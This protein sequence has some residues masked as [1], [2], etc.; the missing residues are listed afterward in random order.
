MTMLRSLLMMGVAAS[1]LGSAA[2]AQEPGQDAGAEARDVI[3]VT[4]QRRAESL[5]DVPIAVSAFPESR[6][7][8]LQI[9]EP[10]DLIE[11][12]PNTIGS[13]NT[14]IGQANAYYIRGLGNTETIAT[15]D[16]PVGTYVDEIYVTRQNGNNVA[17]FDV[18]RVEVLRG[19]QGTLFGR[20]TTGGAVAVYMARPEEEFGYF[21][22][23]GVGSYDRY[24]ARGSV[25][26][27]V[28][29]R[30]LTKV[31]GYWIDEE[32]FVDNLTTG[33]TLNGQE[34]HGLRFDLTW[35]AS[36]A[37]RWDLGIERSTDDGMNLLNYVEGGSP[38]AESGDGG[39]RVSRTGLSTRD[40]AG[41][42]LTRILDGCG[43]GVENDT[44]AITSN[45]EVD[46][47][48]GT[49]NF[50]TGYRD[51]DQEFILDF[52]DGG[53]GGQGFATGGFVIGNDGEHE[54]LSQ[55]I[56]YAGSFWNDRV[57]VVAGAFYLTEDNTTEFVDVFT[58]PFGPNGFPFVLANRRLENTLDTAALYSQFDVHV[59]ERL[60]LTAG[61]RWTEERKEIDFFDL[62]SGVP[63][64]QRLDTINL[65][66]NGI[67]TEQTTALITP[68]VAAEY[69]V[70]DDVMVFASYTEGFKSGGWNARGT[71]PALLQPFFRE[72]AKNWEAGIRSQWL[73]DSLLVNATVFHIQVEDLQAP[74][75]FVGPTGAITFITLNEAGLENTGFELE[76]TASPA[77]GLDLYA[78][79]GLQDAE[80]TDL[81]LI[82]I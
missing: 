46:A 6:L 3:T 14:G 35:L 32:G 60:T 73:N 78:I 43:L 38:L 25:D 72:L 33:E 15:F 62:R 66:A 21:V 70:N 69:D 44:L 55:E 1:A 26:L 68:R 31:S 36:D 80:Y 42:L 16:P 56:K 51:L 41:D 13:N 24:L 67:P 18:D 74:S 28:N 52:F 65:I 48:A 81:S 59:T 9:T 10:L 61:A 11:Y 7:E 4:A 45:I 37:V 2:A 39:D 50:I 22:E 71:S 20:N 82:H 77:E 8:E 29:D 23:A 27:P 63:A 64:D 54:Q 19:P 75:A 58:L 79:L 17:F 47:M 53:L 34:A 76:V 49:F 5:Q 57:D 40:C 12:V 30:L